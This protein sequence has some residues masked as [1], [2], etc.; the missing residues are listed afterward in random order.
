[1][2]IEEAIVYRL[3]TH[4]T[5]TDVVSAS[6]INPMAS[7][8]TYALPR[9]VYEVTSTDY[10]RSLT[11]SSPGLAEATIDFDCIAST[12]SSAKSIASIL[13]NRLDRYH[14]NITSPGGIDETVNWID[15][16]D[17]DDAYSQPQD[18]GD[19]GEYTVRMTFRIKYGVSVPAGT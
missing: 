18:G 19:K 11:G 15:L 5:L 1:M 9:I 8:Q 4:S 3:T 17:A 2:A 14:G 12:Y 6:K 13:R 10:E 7:S 16:L